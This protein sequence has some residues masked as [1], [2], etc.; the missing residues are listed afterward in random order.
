MAQTSHAPELATL[1]ITAYTQ[2]AGKIHSEWVPIPLFG[3]TLKQL[4]PEFK[5]KNYGYKDLPTLVKNHAELFDT[6]QQ[7]TG[8][9]KHVELRLRKEHVLGSE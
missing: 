1:L 6:R 7:T 4:D 8:K 3:T 2:A 5:A 9:T